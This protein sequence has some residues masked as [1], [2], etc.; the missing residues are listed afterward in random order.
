MEPQT[1]TPPTPF[2]PKIEIYH[3]TWCPY[4]RRA[5]AL[6]NDK[7][8]AFEDID[9]TDDTVRESEMVIRSGRTSVPEIFVDGELIGGYDELAALNKYGQL[10]PLLGIVPAHYREAA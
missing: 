10:D 2:S 6:L 7:G 3:K 8:I 4:S 1:A 9:V 5:L